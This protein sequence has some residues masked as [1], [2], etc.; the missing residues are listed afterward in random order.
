MRKT[1]KELARFVLIAGL[2]LM[3]ATAFA[4]GEEDD[5]HEVNIWQPPAIPAIDPD[6][7]YQG[8][9][10]LKAGVQDSWRKLWGG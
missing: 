7:V 10:D 6:R 8:L 2:V 1:G 5:G 4:H 9:G 3:P